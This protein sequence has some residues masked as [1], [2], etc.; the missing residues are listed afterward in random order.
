M[1]RISALGEYS[2]TSHA[3]ECWEAKSDGRGGKKANLNLPTDAD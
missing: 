1:Y 2:N 3:R